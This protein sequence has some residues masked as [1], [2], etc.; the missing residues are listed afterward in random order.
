MAGIPDEQ[1]VFEQLNIALSHYQRQQYDQAWA[2]CQ[3]ALAMNDQR[4]AIDLQPDSPDP[5]NNLANLWREEGY[6]DEAVHYYQRALTLRPDSFDTMNSLGSALQDACRVEEAV[7]M[8]SRA[9]QLRPYH[10]D[11]L[12]N[13]A[14]AR[15]MIGDYARGWQE[16]EW[17]W[18]REE[19]MSRPFRQPIWNGSP[20]HGRTILIHAEQGLGDGIQF[21]RYIPM[22]AACGGRIIL[23][24]R[25]PLMA[26]LRPLPGVVDVVR[27]NDPLPPFDCHIPLLTLPYIFATTLATLPKRVPY[28][29]VDPAQIQAW[30]ARIRTA[31]RVQG[32]D[33]LRIGLVWGG[34]PRI[35]ND[36]LRSPRLGVLLPLLEIPQTEFY[37]LQQGDGRNDL[38]RYP[39]PDNLIDIGGGAGGAPVTDLV[40]TAALM[41]NLDLVISSDTATAHLAGAL[42]CPLW[43]PLPFSPDWRWLL[44]REDSPWYPTARLF[45]QPR[46]RQWEAVV[47]QLRSALD[48]LL[49]ETTPEQRRQQ[50]RQRLQQ[51]EHPDPS[52][53]LYD[54]TCLPPCPEPRVV[55]GGGVPEVPVPLPAPAAARL[56]L[57]WQQ[58]RSGQPEVALAT[59]LSLMPN[60]PLHAG[61]W[62][63]LAGAY[64]ALQRWSDALQACRHAIGLNPLDVQAY[65]QLARILLAQR[66]RESAMQA[67]RVCIHL[68]TQCLDAVIELAELQLQDL[69]TGTAT[70]RATTHQS[71]LQLG[72]HVVQTLRA[73][74]SHPLCQRAERVLQALPRDVG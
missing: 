3:R 21:A 55:M 74:P 64:H 36:H 46:P 31:S 16:Y 42:G 30:H 17:R 73:E 60:H 66:E 2:Y 32:E 5:C 59:G 44:G 50:R 53:Y 41:L 29:W 19:P 52:A 8:F 27:Q 34:S 40:D 12:W 20:L 7:E 28:L 1:A 49:R 35:R 13:R 69:V 57:A 67:Y 70:D 47:A 11:A 62:L 71:C 68:D 61:V 26:L 4:G 9:L 56:E 15:L 43:V 37:V 18:H 33:V 24:V 6:P 54:V 45:R 14:L 22:V 25:E 23:E 10:T 38:T 39:L 63:L 65:L 58:Y 48:G 51:H 72:R